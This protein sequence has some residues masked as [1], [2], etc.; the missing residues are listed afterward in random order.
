MGRRAGIFR[1][2]LFLLAFVLTESQSKDWCQRAGVSKESVHCDA[3]ISLE[4]LSSFFGNKR[5]AVNIGARDGIDHDPLYSV[6]RNFSFSGI[7][8]EGNP[9]MQPILAAN[10]ARANRSHNVHVIN[11]FVSSKTIGN[12]FVQFKIPQDLDILKIDIDSQ[13]FAILAAVMGLNANYKPRI[14]I[15]E[16]NPD[17]PPPLSWYL[18]ESDN[19]KYQNK[20]GWF[21]SYGASIDALFTLMVRD[22]D[23]ALVDIELYDPLLLDDERSEHNLWFVRRSLIPIPAGTGIT[24]W[25]DMVRLFWDKQHEIPKSKLPCLH[26]HKRNCP[27]EMIRHLHLI[28]SNTQVD[29]FTAS[30]SLA[31]PE[32]NAT[33]ISF[34]Q[35]VSK[36]MRKICGPNCVMPLTIT[37][38]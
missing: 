5:V 21:G 35:Q 19:F 33:A 10:M 12:K 32:H 25:T 6:Y 34:G 11:E 18:D 27:L 9:A 7:L 31:K 20:Y 22:Y 3:K 15:V 4:G 17:L 38:P 30:L 24:K 26:I 1:W 36:I 14:V 8:F 13:D 23:Y 2:L 28:D 16:F 29:G 37:K